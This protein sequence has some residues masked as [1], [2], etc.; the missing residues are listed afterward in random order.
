VRL[1]YTILFG[2]FLPL[3]VKMNEGLGKAVGLAPGSVLVHAIGALFGVI[4]ILPF[5]GTNWWGG[6]TQAPTWTLFGGII[7]TGMVVLANQGVQ[8][9]GVGSFIALNVSAQLLTGAVMDHLGLLGSP[10][11]PMSLGRLAGMILLVIGSLLV[12]RT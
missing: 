2:L 6:L 7:G 8:A 10:L 1:L 4:C 5:C 3:I 12:V 11:H 9:L